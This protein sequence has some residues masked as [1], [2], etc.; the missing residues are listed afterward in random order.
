MKKKLYILTL[1]LCTAFGWLACT[2]E[3]AETAQGMTGNGKEIQ[4]TFTTQVPDPID[5]QA[6][7]LDPM[8]RGIN[9]LW[10]FNFNK[11]GIFL[12]RTRATLTSASGTLKGKFQAS[13]PSNT[14]IVHLLANQNLDSFDDNAMAGRHENT[15]MNGMISTSGGL[16]YWGRVNG[17]AKETADEF[18]HLFEDY[19]D[20]GV[21]LYRNMAKITVQGFNIA[22]MSVCNQYA[23]GASV[24]FDSENSTYPNEVPT[25]ITLPEPE[26]RI[27]FADLPDVESIVADNG[28]YIFETPNSGNEELSVII[29]GRDNEKYYKIM[30]I[31]AHKD[32]LPIIRNHSYNIVFANEPA[33]GDGYATY[34]EAKEGAAYNNA[35]ITVDEDIPS[36]TVNDVTLSVEKTSVVYNPGGA[37]REMNYTYTGSET[38][39]AEWISNDGGMSQKITVKQPEG[40][41]KKGTLFVSLVN[42]GQ[43]SKDIHRGT[44]RL[45]AGPLVR[46]IKV[47]YLREL[48]KFTPTWISSGVYNGQTGRDVAFVFEIPE[49]YPQELLPVRCLVTANDLDGNGVVHLSVINQEDCLKADG[50]VDRELYGVQNEYGYKYVY[51]AQTTGR[52]RIYFQT[53]RKS[54]TKSEVR[55]EAGNFVTATETITFTSR[56][57]A[58]RLHVNAIEGGDAIYMHDDM[59]NEGTEEDG[60]IIYYYMVPRVVGSRVAFRLKCNNITEK[61]NENLTNLPSGVKIRIYTSNLVAD[62]DHTEMQNLELHEA[63]ATEGRYYVYTTTGDDKLYFKTT[64]P[65]CAEVVRF[66]DNNTGTPTYRSV[67]ME[68]YNYRLWDFPLTLKTEAGTEMTMVNYGKEVPVQLSFD[69]KMTIA[70]ATPVQGNSLYPNGI[71]EC[72]LYTENLTPDTDN[73]TE[74]SGNYLDPIPKKDADGKTYYVYHV[75]KSEDEDNDERILHFKTNRIVNAETVTLKPN[76][77]QIN[78]NESAV[79]F[80]NAPITGHLTYGTDTPVPKGSFVKLIRKDGTRIGVVTVGNAG[81]YSM[82]LRGEYTFGWE[83]NMYMYYAVQD[84]AGTIYSSP[85]VTLNGLMQHGDVNLS[86]QEGGN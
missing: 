46:Y 47:Y 35:L 19:K 71:Y 64:V 30:L 36:I 74:A 82:T 67:P 84:K 6:R 52:H 62:M 27:R 77:E 11:D 26:Y 25:R 60:T 80:T 83:E 63:T 34:K 86:E 15:V 31:D 49:N 20:N 72:F 78:F 33:D 3:T 70:Q 66:S 68:L 8:G 14:R 5:I 69:L 43:M 28:A 7:A 48:F 85:A 13:I 75:C 39:T 57:D 23:N 56:T 76:P 45:K 2:D 16:V 21:P 59:K 65:D 58:K 44:I 29:K 42:K 79:T 53:S 73:G 38:V 61:D 50:T 41:E 10:L 40:T 12:N 4:L 37:E 22:G 81:A 54:L 17:S 1:L 24:P 51:E 9:V 32:P 55:L 18:K